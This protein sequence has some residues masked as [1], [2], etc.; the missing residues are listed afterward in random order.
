[1]SPYKAM[2][3]SLAL[4]G[5]LFFAGLVQSCTLGIVGVPRV[6]TPSQVNALSSQ[7][8]GK[9]IQVRGFLVLRPE[10]QNMYESKSKFSEFSNEIRSNKP[11]FD[12]KV[13]SK[14]CLTIANPGILTDNL[15]VFANK[16]LEVRGTFMS[17]YIESHRFDIAAC[18]L[19]A[20]ILI[21]EDDLKARY[22]GL[23]R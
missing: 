17:N 14:Y 11:E 2:R 3:G 12:P 20:A 15:A 9:K 19:P 22:P 21:D 16:T 18:P 7:F 23:L 13:W 6:L 5:I 10:A 1:M 4:L 8:D